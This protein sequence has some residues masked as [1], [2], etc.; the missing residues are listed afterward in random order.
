MFIINHNT[1]IILEHFFLWGVGAAGQ[2]LFIDSF[3]AK[4]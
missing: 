2:G 3:I 1:V 4:R